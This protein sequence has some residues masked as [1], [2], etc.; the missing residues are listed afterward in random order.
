MSSL[1]IPYPQCIASPTAGPEFSQLR[2]LL[3]LDDLE[4]PDIA[5]RGPPGGTASSDSRRRPAKSPPPETAGRFQ[6]P[7]VHP[8]EE[9]AGL[10]VLGTP[11]RSE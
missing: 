3:R 4:V 6:F 11:A 5:K 8:A 7:P 2:I 9:G 1:I 10:E